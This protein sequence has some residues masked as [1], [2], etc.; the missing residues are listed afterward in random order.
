M[1]EEAPQEV[2][3]APSADAAPAAAPPA[4]GV[5]V[6]IEPASI[7]VPA[8]GGN[9]V[10][11]LQNQNAGVSG[12]EFL[13]SSIAVANHTTFPNLQGRY[14]FKIK[15]TNNEHYR[16]NPVFGFVEPGAAASVEVTRL[17]S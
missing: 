7:Q 17:V 14:S 11:Q 6:A 9:A 5:P 1:S 16:V 2:P 4:G 8:A 10:L 3:E 15:S 12:T 13:T